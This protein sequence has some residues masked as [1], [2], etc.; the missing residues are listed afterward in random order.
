MTNTTARLA[1]RMNRLRSSLV[2]DILAATAKPGVI[3]FAGGLP[4]AGLMPELPLAAVA[5]P[6]LYQYGTSEG[7]PAFREAVAEWV[8]ETGLKVQASQVLA[9]AGSQQGLDFAAKLFID[10]GTPMVTEAPTYVAALQVF[11]LF[12][13]DLHT[14]PLTAEGPDL[15]LLE[16]T[17]DRHRPRCIYLIPCFQNPSGA[18][19]A[20]EH[21]AAIA[22]L[23]D[24]YAVTL[25]EDEP[26]RSLSL[27]ADRPMTPISSLLRR[28]DWIYLGSFS[29]ILWPGWRLGYLAA[30][31]AL[32]PHLV[33]LKQAADLHTQRPGQLAVAHWLKSAERGRDLERLKNGYR[34][35]RDAMQ[36]ALERHF[37][38]IAD[39]E[40]P[41]GGL[42]FWLRLRGL[43][44]R[45]AEL[46]RALEQNVAFMPG[47]AFY[48]A[49]ATGQQTMRLNY[50]RATP[51]E[52]ETGLAILADCLRK[53]DRA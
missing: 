1:Q 3:S 18:C 12:G 39:W 24:H 48:P 7:E 4:A 36:T 9:L 8:S 44:A 47:E 28:A 29:K 6:A 33:R 31:P 22:A 46:D 10:E 41:Q 14:V 42:F 13:A 50:S 25:I 15:S 38:D 23:L 45:R 43:Q 20:E 5:D 17:L 2:R 16:K 49:Q 30:S 32:M 40:T 34:I 27:Q 11:E 53:S 52:M 37:G 35:R 19:Y 26:Y 21:R 51:E